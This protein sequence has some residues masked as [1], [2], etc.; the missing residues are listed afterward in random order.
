MYFASEIIESETN[1][2]INS[3]M[4]PNTLN[5][6]S[7]QI[8]DFFS[9]HYMNSDSFIQSLI[10]KSKHLIITSVSKIKLKANNDVFDETCNEK[11]ISNEEE[12]KANNNN[13]GNKIIKEDENRERRELF[14]ITEVPSH[15][16]FNPWVLNGY[17]S[18]NLT[19]IGCLQS[20][21]YFHNETINIL[22]HAIPLVY[23]MVF[24]Y[25]MI[26][27]QRINCSVLAYFHCFGL[28]S[29]AFGSATYHLFMNHRSGEQ[30][31][32]RLLQWDMIGIWVTQ[33]FGA[34]TTIYSSVVTFP[35]WFQYFFIGLYAI[36]SLF[37][38]REGVLADSAWKRPASFAFL[39]VMR[40]IAIGLR[41]NTSPFRKNANM[42]L[43]HVI[44]QEFWP[45]VGAFI[46]ATRIPER[47]WPGIFDYFFNSHNIMHCFVVFG[48]IHMHWAT[49]DD[50]IWLSS[51]N[52]NAII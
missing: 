26:P 10:N 24:F 51:N 9:D 14:K 1:D 33:S 45:L 47:Y 27:W 11:F 28:V 44:M 52:F 16:R 29:W 3:R 34:I 13:N 48:A 5:E 40:I 23:F 30:V 36:L 22:T 20:L 50:L 2:Y 12:S 37:S 42:Q 32:Y 49:H 4:A 35:V 38:L 46:S 17:R 25:K 8:S 41:I 6:E 43:F 21:T 15:L 19:A 18:P 7:T 39:F 31:Y